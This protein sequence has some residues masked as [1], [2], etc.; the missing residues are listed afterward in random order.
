MADAH[1]WDEDKGCMITYE[2]THALLTVRTY[3]SSEIT[4]VA[5]WINGNEYFSPVENLVVTCWGYHTVRVDPL[6]CRLEELD[7]Y[8]YTF[9]R[10]EDYSTKNPRTVRLGE[11]DK[12]ITAYYKKRYRGSIG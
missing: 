2:L 6:F 12:T 10:W 7:I 4:D 1:C 5:T 11:S 8:Q 3:A 9:V